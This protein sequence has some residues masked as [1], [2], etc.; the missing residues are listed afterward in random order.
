V[1]GLAAVAIV[2]WVH[3]AAA[4]GGL[5]FTDTTA[6]SGVDFRHTDGRDG[7]LYFIETIGSG[8]ALFDVDNDGWLDI[9]FVNAGSPP[10]LPGR[11]EGAGANRLY[12]NMGDGTFTESTERAGVGD[13]GF[14]VGVCVGDYDNDGWADMYVTG[15]GGTT[16]YHNRGDGT[17]E[18]VTHAAG[19]GV[20]RWTTAATFADIDADGYLDL[21]VT[22]YCKWTPDDHHVCHEYGNDV[23]CGP[24]EFEGDADVLL[25]NRGDGTFE[26]ATDAA[27]IAAH[28]GKGLGVLVLDH[29]ADGDRDIYVVNDGTPNLLYS[30]LGDGSFEE[31]GWLVGVDGDD[32]GAAQGSMGVDFGDYDGDG[33]RDLVVTNFQRE[34]NTLYRNDAG[35]FFTDVS[36]IAGL[37]RSLPY[38]SWGAAF[39][40]ADSD[41][42]QDLF[43]ANGHI[44]SNIADY[45]PTTS[46]AQRNRLYHN[47]PSQDTGGAGYEDVTVSAGDGLAIRKVSRGTAAGDIDN[48]GDVD[49]VVSNANDTPDVLRNDTS[50]GASLTVQ[51]VGTTSNASGIGAEVHATVGGLRIVKEARSGGSYVS[52]SDTRIHIGA[53]ASGVVHHLEVR[54]PS[55]TVDTMENVPTGQRIRIVEG[56]GIVDAWPQLKARR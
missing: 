45:D 9:Y 13:T 53:G 43:I 34:V 4:S 7:E 40:D 15:Y 33:L 10:W 30:N 11:D 50:L 51:L 18:D 56:T 21:Y 46:Y 54:W 14:G 2:L 47:T 39:L 23:Y 25:M 38:V 28:A 36:F 37:G 20:D 19:A 6:E 35:G 49:I 44:Q 22:R 16:L 31:I 1:V 41:G 8:C 3:A 27:G 12:R 29:D 55:G 42:R 24:E 48:D 17:F 5:L 52:Q 26:D 32:G